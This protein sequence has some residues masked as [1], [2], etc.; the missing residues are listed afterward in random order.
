MNIIIVVGAQIITKESAAV[1][2]ILKGVEN[3]LRAPNTVG[4]YTPSMISCGFIVLDISAIPSLF[5]LFLVYFYY[6]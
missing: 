2:F 4:L 1:L 3:L 6:F 5:L